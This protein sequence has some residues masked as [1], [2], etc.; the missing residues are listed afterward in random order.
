VAALLKLSGVPAVF[1]LISSAMFVIVV[2][3][4]FFGPKTNG[5]RLEELSQ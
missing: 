1:A 2:M 5:I 4:G 3:V